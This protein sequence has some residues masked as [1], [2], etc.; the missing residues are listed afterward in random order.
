MGF[1]LL[2]AGSSILTSTFKP[3]VAKI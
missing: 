2:Q 1:M 3:V